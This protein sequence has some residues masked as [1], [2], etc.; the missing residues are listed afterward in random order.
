[1]PPARVQ[2]GATEWHFD[3]IAP[4]HVGEFRVPAELLDRTPI[5]G[6]PDSVRLSDVMKRSWTCWLAM[7]MPQEGVDELFESAVGCWNFYT[8]EPQSTVQPHA[9][10][11][12]ENATIVGSTTRP[13]LII[14]E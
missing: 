5:A 7:L 3:K 4:H 10:R 8:D 14:S 9:A 12:V 2:L 1:M 6:V 11:P 13:G